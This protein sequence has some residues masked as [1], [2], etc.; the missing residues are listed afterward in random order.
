MSK[1]VLYLTVFAVLCT[2]ALDVIS[3]FLSLKCEIIST[4]TG[5]ENM[6]RNEAK[7]D[8]FS[9]DLSTDG[10]KKCSKWSSLGFE[11]FEVVVLVT[12]ALA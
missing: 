11:T 8:L 9:L 7:Y 6:I 10:D 5:N 3:Y 2:I 1:G 12:L 4:V